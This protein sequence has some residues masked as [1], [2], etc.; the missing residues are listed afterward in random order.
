METNP[1]PRIRDFT[2]FTSS[3]LSKSRGGKDIGL[4][5]EKYTQENKKER[6][7]EACQQDTAETFE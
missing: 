7:K 2:S 6:K 4:T 5:G 1:N 3:G